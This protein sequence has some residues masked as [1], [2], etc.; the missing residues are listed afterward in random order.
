LIFVKSYLKGIPC[1]FINHS[2]DLSINLV[3]L[4]T[5]KVVK[6]INNAHKDIIYRVIYSPDGKYIV[7]SSFDGSIKLW[8]K[9]L[10]FIK[11]IKDVS[12]IFSTF[13]YHV[14]QMAFLDN[15][16][17]IC[18]GSY[19]EL[20]DNFWYRPIFKINILTGKEEKAYFHTNTILSIAI[21]KDKKT[22]VSSGGDNSDFFIY[23][24]DLNLK[25]SITGKGNA[26][27]AV[28]FSYDGDKIFFGNT[29]YD[30][31]YKGKNPI[32][33][34]FSLIN[35]RVEKY[36]NEKYKNI[37]LT[38][39]NI[40]LK[41]SEYAYDN[42]LFVGDKTFTLPKIN[43]SVTV[44][45]FTDDGKYIIVGGHY[46][47]YK[48]D[49]KTLEIKNEFIGHNSSIWSIA[50]SPDNKFLLSGSADQTMK[51]W[52]IESGNLLCSIFIGSD[53]EWIMWTENGYYN[54]SVNGDK[55][56]G[57]HINQGLFKEALFYGSDRFY[58]QLYKPDVVENIFITRDEKKALELSQSKDSSISKNYDNIR[59]VYPPVIEMISPVELFIK[60]KE[61]KIVLKYTVDN[62]S[63]YPV[64]SVTILL[65]GRVYT[66]IDLSSQNSLSKINLETV[67]E[68]TDK[69]SLI[70]IT[71]KNKFSVSNPVILSV[72]MEIPKRED[73]YYKPD[74][75]VLS[76]G[77][78]K[79]KNQELN[80]NFADKDAM[81]VVDAFLYQK[82]KLYNDVKY[83]LMINGDANRD[84]ILNGL[85]WIYKSVTQKDVAVIF[86]AGHGI[87]DDL[88]VFYFLN[89]EADIDNLRRTAVKWSDFK[90]IVVNLPSKVLFLVDTCHSGNIM[91]SRRGINDFTKAIKDIINSGTGQV[92]MTAT[93]GNSYSYEDESWGHGAFTLSLINGLVKGEADYNKD[94]IITIKELDLFVTTNVS[95]ITEGLQKPTTIIPESVPDFPVSVK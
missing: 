70:A 84:N 89:H 13:E 56:I 87:N 64:E 58:T 50:I 19:S 12:N 32:E 63:N 80:L 69:T 15:N 65:N 4:I 86:V 22:I 31:P 14:A 25:H 88:G 30:T 62:K 27:F 34:S 45:S 93:T 92:I 28:G 35:K 11:V 47:F 17:L 52:D 43:D 9:D 18:G 24:T 82:G 48:L 78:S 37:K 1:I 91:G 41:K 46:G 59:D 44:F 20:Y 6:K 81:A 54:A 77:V 57:F 26:V 68:L 90:D 33:R 36:S 40:T 51:I 67:V 72:E 83:K 55:Y 5:K 10:K 73:V 49:S 66:T 39:N 16:T 38:H 85:D 21:S 94:N 29:N 8:T 76:I 53:N 3:S 42:R 79:Y 75:Y 95:K 23:D 74:L 71:A 7:T 60:V 61:P 2:T